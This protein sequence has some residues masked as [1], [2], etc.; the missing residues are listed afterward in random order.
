M[1]FGSRPLLAIGA[2]CAVSMPLLG[3]PGIRVYAGGTG[4]R[5][6]ASFAEDGHNEDCRTRTCDSEDFLTGNLDSSIGFRLGAE[7]EWRLHPRLATIA[8]ADLSLVSTEYNRSQRDIWLI[9]PA[10]FAG[11]EGVFDPMNASLRAGWGP[12]MTDD[13]RTTSSWFAETALDFAGSSG[14]SVRVAVRRTQYSGYALREAFLGLVMDDGRPTTTPWTY[15]FAAGMSRP[16]T[17]ARRYRLSR[18][19]LWR[20]AIEQQHGTRHR[21]E[22]GWTSTAHESSERTMFRGVPGNRRGITIPSIGMFWA[23]DGGAWR[24]SMFS[25]RVGAEAAQWDDEYLLIGGGSRVVRRQFDIAVTGGARLDFGIDA[26][27]S[28]FA[29]MEYAYWTGLQLDELRTIIGVRS[30]L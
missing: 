27:A 9:T 7:R 24:S 28:V 20:H 26:R 3:D 10:A 2:I 29:A 19:P 13:G 25:Y 21:L 12:A 18:A 11:V 22:Y 1:T 6:N 23:R 4:T 16:G 17:V 8:G 14:S 15:S 5:W 30:K